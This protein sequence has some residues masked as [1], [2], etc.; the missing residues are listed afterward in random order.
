MFFVSFFVPPG[1]RF[2][3]VFFVRNSCVFSGIGSAPGPWFN[4]YLT[5]DEARQADLDC[6]GFAH[7]LGSSYQAGKN[8]GEEMLEKKQ[9]GQQN[10]QMGHEQCYLDIYHIVFVMIYGI[11]YMYRCVVVNIIVSM[12]GKSS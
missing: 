8:R 1:D 12:V 3:N 2:I 9:I 11:N 4:P 7:S 10:E 5:I 6:G